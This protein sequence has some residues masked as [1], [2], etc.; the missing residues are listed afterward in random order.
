MRM[1]ARRKSPSFPK[2]PF[3]KLGKVCQASFGILFS[4]TAV[5]KVDIVY[6]HGRPER[7]LDGKKLINYYSTIY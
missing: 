6:I 3:V 4:T 5:F 1:S 2:P 7:K